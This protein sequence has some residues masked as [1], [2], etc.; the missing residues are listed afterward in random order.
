MIVFCVQCSKPVVAKSNRKK[1]CSNA[2][3][4]KRKRET[5]PAHYCTREEIDSGKATRYFHTLLAEDNYV[6]EYDIKRFEQLHGR[7]ARNDAIKLLVEYIK[8]E[9]PF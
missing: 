2:C 9:R 1:Y 6:L 4:Q 3:K 7:E 5:P 8:N